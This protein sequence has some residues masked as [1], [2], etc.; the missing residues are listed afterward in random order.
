MSPSDPSSAPSS[1]P[2]DPTSSPSQAQPESSSD[3]ST[4][5][6]QARSCELIPSTS[7]G[8]ANRSL[9]AVAACNSR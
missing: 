6:S 7:G 2:S 4:E 9:E 3:S 1:S 8:M 5:Q